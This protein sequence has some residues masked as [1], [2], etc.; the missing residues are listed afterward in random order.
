ML[1]IKSQ[2]PK[3]LASDDLEAYVLAYNYIGHGMNPYSSLIFSKIEVILQTFFW[4]FS[5]FIDSATVPWMSFSFVAIFLIFFYPIVNLFKKVPLVAVSILA[6]VDVNFVVQL[7]RQS[8]ASLVLI[9]SIMYFL[10]GSKKLKFKGIILY[11]IS[12]FTHS[13]SFLFGPIGFA[14]ARTS[15]KYLKIFL[16][17]SALAGIFL[18]QKDNFHNLLASLSEIEIL[19]KASYALNV[20]SAKGGFRYIALIAAGISLFLS[21]PHPLFKIY[22]GFTALALIFFH[23]PIIAPRIGLLGTSIL[24]GLPIGFFITNIRTKVMNFFIKE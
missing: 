4:L 13:V 15:I 9:Y 19:G 12:G 20:L 17:F 11:F 21:I 14:F 7:F 23:I 8:I 24:T 6:F 1:L 5:R 10:S 18:L 3:V 16:I 2:S 22:M